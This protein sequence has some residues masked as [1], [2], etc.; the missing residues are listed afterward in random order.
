MTFPIAAHNR[1]LAARLLLTL[2]VLILALSSLHA[3][4]GL[5]WRLRNPKPWGDSLTSV[6][7]TSATRVF[8]TGPGTALMKST[9]SGVTWT[10]TRLDPTSRFYNDGYVA[11]N[12][13]INANSRMLLVQGNLAFTSTNGDSWTQVTTN[14][15]DNSA[16]I[17]LIYGNSKWSAIEKVQGSNSSESTYFLS[18]STDGQTW[19]RG[20]QLPTVP[21]HIS[22]FNSLAWAGYYYVAGGTHMTPSG[23]NQ[24]AYVRGGFNLDKHRPDGCQ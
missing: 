11:W 13:L 8:A 6:V 9:D 21:G 17:R 10:V 4:T 15:P 22:T 14:L 23:E 2:S 19:T 16:L 12:N 24:G 20:A 7:A 3:Q 18:T 5:N 1:T